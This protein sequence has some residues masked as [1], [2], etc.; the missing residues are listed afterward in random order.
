M[1][2]RTIKSEHHMSQAGMAEPVF[3][4]TRKIHTTPSPDKH[5]VRERSLALLVKVFFLAQTSFSVGTSAFL[6]GAQV[7]QL[8]FGTTVAGALIIIVRVPACFIARLTVVLVLALLLVDSALPFSFLA[9]FSF[10]ISV[11]RCHIS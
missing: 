2:E 1:S 11:L 3:V 5:M 4:E 9:F 7:S 8:C 6:V 10:T